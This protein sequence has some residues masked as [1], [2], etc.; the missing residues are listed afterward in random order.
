MLRLSDIHIRDPFVLPVPEESGYYMYGTIGASCW[1][2]PGGGFDGY[3]SRD[4]ENWDGPFNVFPPAPDFWGKINHWAPEVHRYQGRFYMLASFKADGVCRGTQILAADSPRGPFTPLTAGP[5]TPRDWE[6]LD[7]TLF[8]DVTGKPWIVFVHEWVQV[9]D[10]EIQAMALTPD[11][12]QP[13]GPPS[14]LFRASEAPWAHKEPQQR[15][16]VTDGPFVYRCEDGELLMLWSSFGAEGYAQGIARSSSGRIVGPW[17]QTEKPL[18]GRD[19]GHGMIFRAF[20]GQL[21]LTLHQPNGAPNERPKFI[22]VA[23]R[24]N[25]IVLT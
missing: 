6:C 16:F 23:E 13:A 8:V 3:F 14:L 10:G 19:G 5:V 4:L 17:T 18:F 2:G 22:K 11:L 9:H 15:D 7:G 20:D 12:K 24:G 1:G 25:D 21:Y